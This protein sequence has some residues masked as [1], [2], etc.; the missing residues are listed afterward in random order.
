ML[1]SFTHCSRTQGSSYNFDCQWLLLPSQ[2]RPVSVSTPAVLAC[3]CHQNSWWPPGG[4]LWVHDSSREVVTQDNLMS[5]VFVCCVFPSSPECIP[6]AEIRW[7][8]V[9]LSSLRL[10]ESCDFP[11]EP[12]TSNS[13]YL[14]TLFPIKTST[15]GCSCR[16]RENGK[17]AQWGSTGVQ[18]EER[19]SS[20][21][22]LNHKQTTLGLSW[23]CGLLDTCEYVNM[24]NYLI[25]RA[26]GWEITGLVSETEKLWK[27]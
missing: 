10:T 17:W 6:P 23:N 3:D 19:I 27:V 14:M 15:M 9:P 22:V 16:G 11:Q 4:L 12:T 20:L 24:K 5:A 8:L 18:W 26:I 25:K 13:Q 2:S 1:W 21:G 7:T